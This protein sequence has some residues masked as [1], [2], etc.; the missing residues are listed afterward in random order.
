MKSDSK[1]QAEYDILQKSFKENPLL[2]EK[3]F[4]GCS[5]QH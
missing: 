1:V 5:Y 3:K 4:D 2:L